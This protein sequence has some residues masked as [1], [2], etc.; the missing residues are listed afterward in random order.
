MKTGGD[1]GLGGWE[2]Q[3]GGAYLIQAGRFSRLLDI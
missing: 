3:V 2:N 1:T